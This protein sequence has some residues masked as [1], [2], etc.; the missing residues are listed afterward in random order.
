MASQTK[1]KI[2]GA[3]IFL[4]IMAI[5]IPLLLSTHTQ[6]SLMNTANPPDAPE[7]PVI[8]LEIPPMPKQ[9]GLSNTQKIIPTVQSPSVLQ[10]SQAQV[11][12][13]KIQSIEPL[14]TSFRLKLGDFTYEKNSLRLIETLK[15]DG[16]EAYSE[17]INNQD[18]EPFYRV[19]I[20]PAVSQVEALELQQHL[21]QHLNMH[22]MIVAYPSNNS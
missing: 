12:P 6:T 20:G 19:F 17:T 8:Q 18:R 5:C 1:Q 2:L 9:L 13:P 11:S 16:F 3:V 15:K 7:M 22:S 14:E 21:L 10:V 4:I